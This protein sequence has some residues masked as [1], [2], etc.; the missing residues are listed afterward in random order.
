MNP[1]GAFY[2]L[3]CSGGFPTLENFLQKNFKQFYMSWS[4][5][6]TLLWTV[7]PAPMTILY[8]QQSEH[9]A[10][11]PFWSSQCPRQFTTN[12]IQLSASR[13]EQ[14]WN[15]GLWVCIND[16]NLL[17]PSLWS[18][19]ENILYSLIINFVS[20]I[21]ISLVKKFLMNINLNLTA[22]QGAGGRGAGGRVPIKD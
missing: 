1:G 10:Q 16:S 22:G 11:K 12:L 6:H 17:L 7:Y 15:N 8:N 13:L 2:K 19:A 20:F 4:F 3:S 21:N 5:F 18:S 9:L 14:L